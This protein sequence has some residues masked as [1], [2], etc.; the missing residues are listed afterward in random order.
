MPEPPKAGSMID[1][2]EYS[3]TARIY[4]GDHFSIYR[5]ARD[6]EDPPR[7][8]LIKVLKK[9]RL[10]TPGLVQFE[11]LRKTL[12]GLSSDK[13]LKFLEAVPSEEG[14]ILAWE[15][16]EGTPLKMFRG[17]RPLV[18]ET[19]F[20]IALQL[21][22]AL[23][24][25]HEK[26]LIH[27]N[28]RPLSIFVSKDHRTTK[29]GD[30]GILSVLNQE[31]EEVYGKDVLNEQLPYISPEQ[32]GRMNRQIDYRTDFY[33][34]GVVF[35][36]MLTGEA[37]FRSDDP[38]ELIHAHIA[39][40]P[41]LPSKVN[42]RVPSAVADIVM[43]LLAKNAE[44]R[45]QSAEGLRS[46]LEFCRDQLRSGR[47]IEH[48][49]PGNNDV[50]DRF[51]LPQKLYGRGQEIDLLLKTFY[52]VSQGES[53]LVLV[54]GYPGLGKTMLIHE[55]RKSVAQQNG[56]FVMGEYSQFRG[57]IPHSA[58]IHA[59]QD[60]VHQILLEGEERLAVWRKRLR[61]AL[62]ANGHL[63]IALIPELKLII[64]EQPAM[65]FLPSLEAQARFD[66][67]FQNFIQVFA[68]KEHP[69]ILALDNLQWAD[70]ESFRL[71]K[72]ILTARPESLLV[73]GAYR[74]N[75]IG[76]PH[77]LTSVLKEIE[78]EGV[79]VIQ[80]T[81]S[82]LQQDK[83]Q[84]L[85]ADTFHCRLNDVEELAVVVQEKSHGNPFFINQL[86][87]KL[88]H[89]QTIHF[90][91]G[92]GWRWDLD[93]IRAMQM[94]ETVADFIIKKFNRLPEKT[95]QVLQ[96]ASCVGEEFQVEPISGVCRKT[97]MEVHLALQEA[98][99]EGLVGMKGRAY[100]F[101]HNRIYE[102]IYSSLPDDKKEFAHHRI[103]TLFLEQ[104][105]DEE[106]MEKL[107]YV[108]DQFRMGSRLVI[109]QAEKDRLI[110]LNLL[111]ARRA[112]N[113]AAY[114]KGLGYL[115]T[116]LQFLPP[117][118]W[119]KRYETTLALYMERL[120][121]EYL[122]G[123]F[124]Q[125]EK[126]F[127]VIQ[128]QARTNLDKARAYVFRV[129]L[130]HYQGQYQMAID[131]GREGLR[132]LGVSFPAVATQLAIVKE[133]FKVRY[134]LGFKKPQS[135][136]QV[137][138]V[139]DP[140]KRCAMDL[141]SEMAPAGY[142]ISNELFT[143]V[144]LKV[145]NMSL[146][147]G[148]APTSV[149]AFGMYAMILGSV[150]GQYKRGYE[151]G[152]AALELSEKFPGESPKCHANFAF[153]GFVVHWLKHLK[154][155]TDFV[156]KGYR[157]G[158]ESGNF[159]FGSYCGGLHVTAMRFDGSR[160]DRLQR[161]CEEYIEVFKKIK[162]V[163]MVDALTSARQTT[164][165][166]RG[167]TKDPLTLDDDQFN[168]PDFRQRLQDQ[169]RW[170]VFMI[171][172]L[173]KLENVYLLKDYRTALNLIREMQ[174]HAKLFLG[175]YFSAAYNYY[176]SLA[177]TA[178]YENATYG[179]KR[180]YW[181]TLK[182][183]QKQMHT[184]M[185]YC[186]ENFS[187]K[188]YLVAAEM[189]RIK[190]KNRQAVSLYENAIELAAQNGFVQGQALA[191][192]RLGSL[193]NL[194]SDETSALK[195][196]QDARACY[197][198][199]GTVA[200][201]R[202]LE[203]EY[204]ALQAMREPS[205]EA[206]AEEQKIPSPERLS[207][208]DLATVIKFSQAISREIS[209]EGLLRKL[210]QVAI[211]NAGAQKGLLILEKDDRLFIEAQGSVEIG[212][213][214]V[215]QSIPVE[216][217][218]QLC[219]GVVY[220]VKRTKTD[221]VLNDATTDKMFT[222]DAYVLKNKPKSILSLP[223]IKQNKLIGVLY[224]ENNL[225]ANAFTPERV[226][227]LKLLSSQIAISLENAQLYTRLEEQIVTLR[228]MYEREK[229]FTSTVS[230]ELRTPLAISKQAVSLLFRGKV[231]ALTDKQMELLKV[232]TNNMDRLAVLISDLLDLSRMDAG[233]IELH[234]EDFNVIECIQ[235]N[236]QGWEMRA[237]A[238]KIDL[239][240]KAPSEPVRVFADKLRFTQILSNLL[241]NAIKFT[242][243]EGRVK[244]SIADLK[245]EVQVS[246]RDTGPGISE[247]DLPKL[248]QKYHQLKRTY[249]SGLQ[250]LGLGLNIASSLVE[251]HQ[252]RIFV[253]SKLGE[254]STFSFIIPKS[255]PK[256]SETTVS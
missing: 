144:M 129:S 11:I 201:V 57:D 204:P 186:P 24:Q 180:Q 65:P 256:D 247:E 124:E 108:V 146:K 246:V 248:F 100:R 176:H 55:I 138:E 30:F 25:L 155:D 244:I 60:I 167:L 141:L 200:K 184:W 28:I 72:R 171:Y 3:V 164:A 193:Y 196:L 216:S 194:L 104:L 113:A 183:N 207:A 98:E 106:L 109:D 151:F 123:N 29:L 185:S 178:S 19:F 47:K 182:K 31:L 181:R 202:A 63:M 253:E 134:H 219:A 192:E 34:L 169:E 49:T 94:T 133:I 107:F 73:L 10:T 255:L 135:I 58:I 214:K 122:S 128:E 17:D 199:W 205:R 225:S 222:T 61:E 235:E 18:L 14:L 179:M 117:D 32:S 26:K 70:M 112:K 254:G 110:E 48:F 74:D 131:Y 4:E 156:V 52:Q 115:N 240:L 2:G 90:E 99:Q 132:L 6:T 251:L 12:D 153:G 53:H 41:V 190:K 223:I 121:C 221:V 118:P 64:G 45:Y 177:L 54:G 215:L 250:G 88:Y 148:N 51:Q 139:S 142:F 243:E 66:H 252:G 226:H 173:Y 165:A 187:D 114:S 15:G 159:V 154:N 231:G 166:L 46:D 27:Y 241:D 16:F 137:P 227:I 97:P 92:Q 249:Q 76:N 198:K 191:H 189:A 82:V 236:Y 95:R 7:P 152:K 13:I 21:T 170:F 143:V 91:R 20:E 126:L 79:R 81:L 197:A 96:C 9:I 188:Y 119:Q 174:K 80:I 168:E 22:Q 239:T 145:V 102:Q 147:Y 56:Y 162:A 233:K 67:T 43:K 218:D 212:E 220:Y 37:P 175:L 160:L 238:K 136:L 232:A 209:L 127:T 83:V 69:L 77:P 42:S 211:E 130:F 158:L 242:P 203:S 234:K 38:M 36:E 105:K 163:D 229:E 157:A 217:S 206:G 89:E 149:L 23:N 5:A 228:Q 210:M 230:H 213:A 101:S 111:A 85:L 87:N 62:G 140:R 84:E 208:L 40:Q 75:E 224:L 59:C 195:Q 161:Q 44:E 116:A 8:C 1:V 78:G 125:T 33:S 71:L 172:S 245:N 39:K 50:L 150:F 237:A 103:G 120:E 93:K 35:Y 68:K 86:L